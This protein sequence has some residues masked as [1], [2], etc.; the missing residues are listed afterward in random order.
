MISCMKPILD[1]IPY[2]IFCDEKLN[3]VFRYREKKIIK[4]FGYFV[5]ERVGTYIYLTEW[6]A[7][8]EYFEWR[9]FEEWNI[10]N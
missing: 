10:S 7:L 4:F 3:L 1:W 8:L 5:D 6:V 9:L 2:L